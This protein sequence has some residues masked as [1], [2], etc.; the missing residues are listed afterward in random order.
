MSNSKRSWKVLNWN[1][2]GLNSEEKWNSIRDKIV[3]SG[4]EIICLQETKR[5][6][7]D[8]NY[9]RNFCPANFDSFEFL[10]SVGASGGILVAWKGSAFS[11]HMV[12]SNCFALS[13]E[14]TSRLSN[15]TWMLTVIY[16]PCSDQGKKACIDWFRNIQMPDEVDWLIVGDFNLI[17]KPKD[18]IEK[19]LTPRKCSYLMRP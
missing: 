5:E 19:G 9:L 1:V 11:G 17:R 18:R 7:F 4:A 12:F 2:R 3:E 6:S 13:M 8:S 14:F 10:S 15:D 16:A